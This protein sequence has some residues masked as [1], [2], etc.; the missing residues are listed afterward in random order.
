MPLLRVPDWLAQFFKW[1]YGEEFPGLLAELF[2]RLALQLFL[3]ASVLEAAGRSF[4]AGVN[5][6]RGGVRGES[7]RAFVAAADRVS[8][9]LRAGPEFVRTMGQAMVQFAALFLYVQVTILAITA[10]LFIELLIALKLL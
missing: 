7:E 5:A 2:Y 8:G 6:I 10:L 9:L 3:V 4:A 1:F